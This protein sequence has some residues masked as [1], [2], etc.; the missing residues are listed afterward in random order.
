MVL[1]QVLHLVLEFILRIQNALQ[2]TTITM[3]IVR[4]T[5]LVWTPMFAISFFHP[6]PNET[7]GSSMLPSDVGM[8]NSGASSGTQIANRVSDTCKYFFDQG[9][10]SLRILNVNRPIFS[11]VI[12]HLIQMF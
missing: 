6:N 1:A 4:A 3:P 12:R 7:V 9:Q 11:Q 5:L 8:T 10:Y 2:K